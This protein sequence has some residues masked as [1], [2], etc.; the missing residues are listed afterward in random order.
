MSLFEPIRLAYG[1][2]TH[3][4]QLSV[5]VGCIAAAVVLIM[6]IAFAVNSA[7]TKAEHRV[8]VKTEQLKQVLSLQGE[9]KANKQRQGEQL[10]A[11][12]QSR[13]RL[14]SLVESAARE[15]GVQIGQLRPEDGDPS[16]EG[17][18]ESRV[19]LRMTDLSADRMHKFLEL[20]EGFKGIVVVKRLKLNRPYR[21]DVVDVEMSIST[22]KLRT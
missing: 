6:G 12:G 8:R 7:I 19:D 13:V 20:V 9:Y 3:R 4:E 10:R 2:L 15:A 11:L 5:I 16:P 18:V 17:V 21:K 14:I 22:F 1:R